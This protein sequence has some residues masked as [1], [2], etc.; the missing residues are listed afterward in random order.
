MTTRSDFDDI[1]PY[2]DSELTKVLGRLVGHKEVLAGIAMIMPKQLADKLVLRYKELRSVDQF[3]EEYMFPMLEHLKNIKSTD[4][5]FSGSES[6]RQ[7]ALFLSNHRDIII[8]PAFLQYVL[9]R[10]GMKTSE[11]A[12][13]SNLMAKP[14]ITDAMRVNKS[15]VVRRNLT[16]GEQISAFGELSRYIAHTITQKRASIWLAQREGRAKDSDDRTQISL[17]KMLSLSGEGSFVENI[18]KLRMQ[19][20]AISYEYDVCDYM[21]AKELQ[22]RRD[23]ENFV[24]SAADDVLSMQIGAL[25]SASEIHYAFTPPIDEELDRIAA[26]RLPRNEEV[27]RVA[28]AIDTRIYRAYKIFKTNYIAFDIAE[29]SSRFESNYTEEEKDNFSAYIEQQIAKIEL[30]QVDKAFCR[31]KMLEMYANPLKNK[32]AAEGNRRGESNE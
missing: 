7:P 29:G 18:K 21:K 1:R 17:L 8:D 24:K 31:E 4:I 10:C 14:W 12:I 13:G 26:E 22:Q 20:L 15:F 5:T 11:I 16:R 32:I 28:E 3:Q 6:V 25:G 2:N 9:L 27:R 23:D 19:P 30:R